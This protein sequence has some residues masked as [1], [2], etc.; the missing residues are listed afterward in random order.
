MIKNQKQASLVRQKI[1]E[2]RKA[3][4]EVEETMTDKETSKYELGIKSFDGLI[5]DL[6]SELNRYNS[7]IEGNF[8]C[9]EVKT[10]NEIPQILIAARLSQKIS[11]KQLGEMVGLKEQQIQRYESTDY[12]TAS[13]PRIVE[14][15]MALKLKF[16]FEKIV[17]LNT[18]Y[19]DDFEYPPGITSEQVESAME[20]FKQNGSLIF[21]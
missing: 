7:L 20:Q 1:V 12:E 14:I 17:I 2:L 15:A 16:K 10:L 18:C 13:W 11:Q 9:L 8:H 6:E 21:T 3:K 4:R 5:K 19:K